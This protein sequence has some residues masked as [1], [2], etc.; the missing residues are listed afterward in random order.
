MGRE[1]QEEVAAEVYSYD[2]DFDRVTGISRV[3][4]EG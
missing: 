4:P 3:E 1:V 2:T